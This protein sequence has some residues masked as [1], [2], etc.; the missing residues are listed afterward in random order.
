MGN[1]SSGVRIAIVFALTALHAPAAGASAADPPLAVGLRFAPGGIEWTLRAAAD[2]EIR[3]ATWRALPALAPAPTQITAPSHLGDGETRSGLWALAPP[4][5]GAWVELRVEAVGPLGAFAVGA[6]TRTP[7]T[8]GAAARTALPVTRPRHATPGIVRGRFLYEARSVDAGGYT[9]RVRRLPLRHVEAELVAETTGLA[10]SRTRLDA[11]GRF[12]LPI[13]GATGIASVRLRSWTPDHP[14]YALRVVAPDPDAEDPVAAARPHEIRTAPFVLDPAGIDLG[15]LVERDPDGFGAVQAFHILDVAID[16]FDALG[17]DAFP[18]PRPSRNHALRIFWGPALRIRFSAQSGGVI[19]ITSPASGDTDGWSDAVILHEIGHYVA[20]R[21]LRESSPGGI[22]LLGDVEQN[23]RLAWAE[24]MASAYA[25]WVRDW[26]AATRRDADGNAMDADVARY[27]NVGLPPPD[28]VAGGLQ[29]AWDIEAHRLGSLDLAQDGIGSESTIAGLLW[30]AVDGATSADATPGDDDDTALP[31]ARVWSVL[32]AMRAL[33][34]AQPITFEDFWRTWQAHDAEPAALGPLLAPAGIEFVADSAE[35]DAERA[36]ALYASRPRTTMG[37]VVINEIALG[38][39]I[40][41]EIA[42]RD[43]EPHAL[44]GWSLVAR[45]NASSGAPSLTYTLPPGTRIG[46]GARLVVHRGGSGPA[47]SR[48]IVAENWTTPWFPGFEGAIVLRDASGKAMDFVRWNGR[49]GVASTVPPPAGTGFAGDL[50]AA[51][52]GRVLARIETLVDRDLAADFDVAAASLGAPNDI[53]AVHRTFFPV[54][55]TD[56]LQWEVQRA[57]VYTVEVRRPRN[58]AEPR[59]EVW[60]P[61]AVHAVTQVTATASSRVP[62]RVTLQLEAGATLEARTRHVGQTTRYGTYDV[63]LYEERDTKAANAPTGLATTIAFAG[64]RAHTRVEWWNAGAYDRLRVRAGAG[65]WQTLAADARAWEG[66]LAP[67][68]QRL[69]LEADVG[70]A[71]A[72]A[73]VLA[74][75]VGTWPADVAAAFAPGFESDWIL[76]TGWTT[77]TAA[78][79][80]RGRVHGTHGAAWR[81][82]AVRAPR[83]SVLEFA[84]VC[85]AAPERD[86][87]LEASTDWGAT[88]ERLGR[89]DWNLHPGNGENGAN[90]RDAEITAADWVHERIPL[91]AWADRPLQLRFRVQPGAGDGW[92]LADLRVTRIAAAPAVFAAH[93]HPAQPNPFNPTTRLRFELSHAAAVQLHVYDVRGRLCRTLAAAPYAAGLHAVDW[94]GRDGDGRALASGVYFARLRAADQ[95]HMRKLVLLR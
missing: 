74:L 9:G 82:R 23:L 52:F 34:A 40:A 66:A 85:A 92:R 80:E 70:G 50:E 8:I 95:N 7:L 83:A 58:G 44:G 61:G 3:S 2:V 36:P 84:H 73:P 60:V 30:D 33:P 37:G 54:A 24:G 20:Q 93:L 13:S 89:W 87:V 29:F 31:L 67:G 53:P 71:V 55:D 91:D 27:V 49:D 76:D 12:V 78:D 39:L 15:T 1:R 4:P 14:D 35:P 77:T 46:A 10:T 94:D 16:A 43:S 63:A 59:L 5:P 38:A 25:C 64:D 45:A 79:S 90:W 88:W 65:D 42:N 81:W 18:G 68:L 51:P 48:D 26:R 75:D 47:S 11:D 86:A 62:A 28:G 69:A 22:H 17:T 72:A 57:G 41:I 21:F 56:V 32:R 19:E 6:A